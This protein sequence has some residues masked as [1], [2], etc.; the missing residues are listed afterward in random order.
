MAQIISHAAQYLPQK[1]EKRRMTTM[2]HA[3]VY[4]FF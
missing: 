1:E 2:A 4:L 3:I